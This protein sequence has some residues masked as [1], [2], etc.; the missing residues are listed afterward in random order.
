[1]T[2]S[3]TSSLS[4]LLRGLSRTHLFRDATINVIFCELILFAISLKPT[5]SASF[6]S[7]SRSLANPSSSLFDD[8]R[9]HPSAFRRFSLR[10]LLRAHPLR[11]LFVAALIGL[12]F[13]SF[14]ISCEPNLLTTILDATFNVIS[15]NPKPQNY[16]EPIL[17]AISSTPPSSASSSSPS[18][19]FGLPAAAAGLSAAFRPPPLPPRSTLLR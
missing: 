8:T 6:S 1:V 4:L 9:R 11:N 19:S 13:L 5:S 3:S 12:T 7:F 15:R 16:R 2:P 17:F 18:R 10:H 14:A